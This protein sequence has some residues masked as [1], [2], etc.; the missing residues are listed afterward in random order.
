M[1]N[2]VTTGLKLGLAAG[3]IY[4]LVQGGLL[5][6]RQLTRIGDRWPWLLVAQIPLAVLLL[7]ASVRWHLLMRARQVRIRFR[8][9]FAIM[10]VGWFF[11]QTMPSNTGGDVAKAWSVAVDHPDRRSEAIMSIL[12]DRLTGLV[13]LL[14]FA[15]C[16]AALNLDLIRSDAR[17]ANLVSLAGLALLIAVAGIFAFYSDTLRRRIPIG[18][19]EAWAVRRLRLESG[20]VVGRAYGRVRE[21]V[22]AADRAVYAYRSHRGTLLACLGLSFV[23]HSMTACVNLSLAWALLGPDFE[24][25]TLLL[26]VPLAHIGM[27]LGITPG[28]VGVGEV[29]YAELFRWGGIAQGGLICVLQRLCWISWALVGGI[30]FML[31]GGRTRG[32][33]TAQALT[34]SGA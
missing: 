21:L 30:V 12:V 27:T 11:N 24:A 26:L 22:L 15:L 13:A 18:P 3:L 33:P 7:A 32:A 2:F 10:L 8:D 17:I 4:L 19:L 16:A 29:I 5:D 14:V 23:L 28:N 34:G 6:L 20:G 1:R 9:T 25:R 31:R